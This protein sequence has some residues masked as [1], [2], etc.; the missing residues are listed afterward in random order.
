M[1][2]TLVSVIVRKWLWK[3]LWEISTFNWPK[4]HQNGNMVNTK[5]TWKP[6]K[7]QLSKTETHIPDNCMCLTNFKC[8]WA[9]ALITCR[10]NSVAVFLTRLSW[11]QTFPS[12]TLLDKILGLWYKDVDQF[13]FTISPIPV[14]TEF[15]SLA[16]SSLNFNRQEA[17]LCLLHKW[18]EN[19][20]ACQ[21][22]ASP[23]LQDRTFYWAQLLNHDYI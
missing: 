2:S 5:L 21:T 15:L 6:S 17:S 11:L 16:W 4:H 7:M 22:V 3:T 12:P 20:V 18:V 9:C 1:Q 8:L 14:A 23:R 10:T 19:K 13:I